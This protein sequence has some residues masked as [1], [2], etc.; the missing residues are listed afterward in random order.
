[1]LRRLA[2]E[3]KS[4]GTC[5]LTGQPRWPYGCTV[6][7]RGLFLALGAAHRRRTEPCRVK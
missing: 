2:V 4:C 3:H 7:H 5:V 1:M 6:L